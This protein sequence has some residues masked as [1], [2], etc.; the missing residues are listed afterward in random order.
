MSDLRKKQKKGKGFT[1][2]CLICWIDCNI[3]MNNSVLC[4]LYMNPANKQT[5][6]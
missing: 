3:T 1:Y 2:H 4:I 6:E 5:N